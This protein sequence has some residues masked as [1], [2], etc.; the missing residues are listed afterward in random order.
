MKVTVPTPSLEVKP[1]HLTAVFARKKPSGKPFRG[2][3]QIGW[4]HALFNSSTRLS[5]PGNPGYLSGLQ[6]NVPLTERLQLVTGVLYGQK[7]V[8]REM[9]N[10]YTPPPV[11]ANVRA[12]DP[13]IWT[14]LLEADHTVIE[15]PVMLRYRLGAEGKR[16][17]LALQAGLS[18]LMLQKVQ[19]RHFDPESPLNSNVG[20]VT[21]LRSLNAEEEYQIGGAYWGNFRIAPV[22]EYRLGSSVLFELA[23]YLQYGQQRVGSKQLKLHSAG[24]AASI[25]VE[26]GKK[27][28]N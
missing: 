24:G 7:P 18:G 10:V 9:L 27:S 14:S 8:S 16:F 6:L 3:I 11:A 13:V 22:I 5:D 28:V 12:G 2:N 15:I 26:I 17:N 20:A 21:D 23:P 1:K 19:Y 4:T 25:L